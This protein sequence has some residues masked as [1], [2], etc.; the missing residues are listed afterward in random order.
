MRSPEKRSPFESFNTKL[1]SWSLLC[2][3]GYCHDGAG[4]SPSVPKKGNCTAP[5]ASYIFVSFVET[6]CGRTTYWY[7]G[8]VFAYFWP[9]SV[10]NQLR[11]VGYVHQLWITIWNLHDIFQEGSNPKSMPWLRLW[12]SLLW[13][14]L[15]QVSD[16]TLCF[17]VGQCML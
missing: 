1:S 13:G 6:V 7:N 5:K 12:A 9:H 16:I 17:D 10:Y 4:L 11:C 3:Q 2:A 15:N 14:F 8:Q